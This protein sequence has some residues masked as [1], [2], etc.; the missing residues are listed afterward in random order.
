LSLLPFALSLVLVLF[1]G[2]GHSGA[3]SAAPQIQLNP[4]RNTID[5]TG[6][7]RATLAALSGAALSTEEWQAVLRVSVQSG[8]AA[9]PAVA[10]KYHVAGGVLRFT[11]LF[12]LDEGRQYGGLQSIACAW[13]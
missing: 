4:E 12:S 6:L 2:C 3:R 10:G 9:T 1:T 13:R 7:P 11:P 8:E 5:V